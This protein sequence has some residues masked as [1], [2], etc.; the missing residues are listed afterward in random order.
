MKTLQ[1]PSGG[2]GVGPAFTGNATCCQNVADNNGKLVAAYD[3]HRPT[4]AR[5]RLSWS[6]ACDAAAYLIDHDHV[7]SAELDGVNRLPAKTGD[8]EKMIR[9]DYGLKADTRRVRA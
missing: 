5:S 2:Q 3:V 6:A 7:L 4:L 9:G 1:C 8:A